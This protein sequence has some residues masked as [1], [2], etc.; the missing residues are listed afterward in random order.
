MTGLRGF[1]AIMIL[2][3][4]IGLLRGK[5]GPLRAPD[6][7]FFAYALWSGVALSQTSPDQA[8]ENA[9]VN[10]IEFLGAYLIGRVFI[11]TSAQ[12][13]RLILVL[14]TLI[15]A[16]LPLALYEALTGSPVL[17]EL[18]QSLPG[19]SSV[20]ALSIEPRLGLDRAQVLLAHPSHYGLFC[21]T[22]TALALIGLRKRLGLMARLTLFGVV[23]ACCFLALSSGAFLSFLLQGFL[24]GW[25]AILNGVKTRW[26]ILAAMTCFAYLA[27]DLISTRTPLRVFMSYAT[28]SSHNAYWRGIIFE[29]GLLSIAER[30]LFGMG[31]NDW[32]RPD[33]MT[34]RSIDNFW[35]LIAMRYGI[36]GV[37]LLV[38]GYFCGLITVIRRQF[39][40]G[41]TIVHQR[42]A[43]AICFT[44]LTLTLCTVHVWTAIYS[45][46]FFL[47]GAGLWMM[48]TEPVMSQRPT[49]QSEK[50][51]V[52][53]LVRPAPISGYS[54]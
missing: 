11:Q 16:T 52:P 17:I 54:T 6:Y 43:W 38:A 50:R 47:F 21:S 15:C 23:G 44:G 37:F 22:V 18:I 32:E 36:P 12:F 46:V 5:F 39:E 24:I 9:S 49:K 33:F 19:I 14:C 34:S 20:A 53:V 45:Y 40:P 51:K 4:T 30:P 29:W 27:V 13:E 1:L 41:T 26:I 8:L 10:V 28:F 42:L 25:S 31:F 7:L 2:P 35:L 3:L 48:D